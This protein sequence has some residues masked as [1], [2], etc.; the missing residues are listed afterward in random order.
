MFAKAGGRGSGKRRNFATKSGGDRRRGRFAR[1][2]LGGSGKGAATFPFPS[3][4]PSFYI[5]QLCA[6][7]ATSFL[8]QKPKT[9]LAPPT[10]WPSIL[11]IWPRE[12]EIAAARKGEWTGVSSLIRFQPIPSPAS[13]TQPGALGE[14]REERPRMDGRAEMESASA[15]SFMAPH[16]AKCPAAGRGNWRSL[17]SALCQT[18]THSFPGINQHCPALRLALLTPPHVA[19][20]PCTHLCTHLCYGLLNSPRLCPLFSILCEVM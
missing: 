6:S 4:S 18:P 2:P 9:F 20:I 19:C 13:I 11:L 10:K 12:E 17:S 8:A 7:A 14:E 15:P 1:N 16:M 3:F 5:R